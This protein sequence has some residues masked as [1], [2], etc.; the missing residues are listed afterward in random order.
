MSDGPTHPSRITDLLLIVAVAAIIALPFIAGR[1][2]SGAQTVLVLTACVALAAIA[3]RIVSYA[4][5]RQPAA[6]PERRPTEWAAPDELSAFRQ[7]AS[8]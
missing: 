2:P 6:G 7:R 1:N 8:R 5:R 4:G 3:F